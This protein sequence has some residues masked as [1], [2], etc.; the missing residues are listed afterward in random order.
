LKSA[1][2]SPQNS[3]S[4]PITDTEFKEY[5]D[6]VGHLVESQAFRLRAFQGG[7]ESSLRKVAWRHLLNIFPGDLNG[8]ERFDYLKRKGEE[9]LRLRQEWTDIVASQQNIPEEIRYVCSMVRK[10]VLRT[11][12][13]HEFFLGPDDGPNLKALNNVLVTYALAHPSLSYCQGMSDLAATMLIVQEDESNAYVCFC[14]LMQRMRGNFELDGDVMRIKFSHLSLLLQHYDPAF[15]AWLKAS[16]ADDLLFC[17]RW[18]LLEL[19]REFPL[20]DALRLFEVMWSSI[21]PAHPDVE[22]PL[23]EPDYRVHWFDKP[24][25]PSLGLVSTRLHRLR[26]RSLSA[27]SSSTSA[28]P[29]NASTVVQQAINNDTALTEEAENGE[30]SVAPPVDESKKM[31]ASSDASVSKG[32]E[33]TR[34]SSSRMVVSNSWSSDSSSNQ[35]QLTVVNKSDNPRSTSSHAVMQHASHET[36]AGGDSSAVARDKITNAGG[37]GQKAKAV[38]LFEELELAAG[39]QA[40]ANS[41]A[42][43]DSRTIHTVNNDVFGD[44]DE[45]DDDFCKP[46]LGRHEPNQTEGGDGP[47]DSSIVFLGS[48][49]QL[50]TLPRPEELGCGNPFLLFICLAMLLLQRDKLMQGGRR[51][52]YDEIAITFDKMVRK[53]EVTVVLEQARS[54]YAAYIRSQ[55]LLP[56]PP[57]GDSRD[58]C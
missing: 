18:L 24:V 47:E 53:H 46:L 1:E 58:A 57:P 15:Y 34:H 45:E 14:G 52:E 12:R 49:G 43:G 33:K 5:L 25:E 9:Y 2:A 19:K 22:L 29:T 56:P 20:D 54:L 35:D 44:D 31:G 51:L 4:S 39:R 6:N 3:G 17:Y 30:Q 38:S 23:T 13:Q 40:V 28:G 48:A 8:R 11:D 37:T 42:C 50:P 7:I 10:D 36:A 21:P 26:S 55:Q 27:S 16:A 41:N 32:G